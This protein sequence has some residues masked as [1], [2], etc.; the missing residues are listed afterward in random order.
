[1]TD[2][3]TKT[4]AGALDATALGELREGFRGAVIEPGTPEY[5]ESRQVFNGMFD[6]RPAVILRPAG[7][8]DVIRAIGM[9]QLTGLPLAIRGGA[10]SVAGFSMCDDGIVIDMRGMTGIRV[11]PHRRTVR[12]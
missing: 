6:R 5:D 11:D 12:A 3:R 7:T 10:H 2:T 8:A 9:A 1:M 4:R